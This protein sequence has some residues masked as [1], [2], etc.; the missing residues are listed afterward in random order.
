MT[1][2]FV[3][4]KAADG[5]RRAAR[6]RGEQ[7]DLMLRLRTGQFASIR[8][9]E[10]RAFGGIGQIARME[11]CQ[12]L[13]TGREVRPPYVEVAFAHPSRFCHAARRAPRHRDAQRTRRD[14]RRLDTE[15]AY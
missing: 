10:L 6:N 12:Q 3:F 2:L 9:E 4:T 11:A 14:T 13:T 1:V 8:P 5:D 7:V 15:R